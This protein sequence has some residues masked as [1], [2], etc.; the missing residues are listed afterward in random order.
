MLMSDLNLQNEYLA[1]AGALAID[2]MPVHYLG[3]IMNVG[4]DR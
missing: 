4:C 3:K 2:H 1:N